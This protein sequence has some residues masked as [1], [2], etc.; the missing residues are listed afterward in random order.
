MLEGNHS[1]MIFTDFPVDRPMPSAVFEIFVNL[2]EA[3]RVI[4]LASSKCR[5]NQHHEN[6]KITYF[7]DTNLT[8]QPAL[9]FDI[10]CCKT[11]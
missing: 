9:I 6:K 11:N 1:Y 7:Q 4:L 2:V 8:F 3:P 10:I 5:N